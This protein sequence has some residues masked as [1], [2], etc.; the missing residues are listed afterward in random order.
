[1]TDSAT[2]V[3][4]APAAAPETQETPTPVAPELTAHQQ[5]LEMLPE[6]L[7]TDPSF[8]DFKGDNI[9]DV[10][11]K[12]GKS[13]LNTKKLVGADKNALLK[14]PAAEDDKDGWNAVYN[15]LGRPETPEGYGLEDKFKDVPGFSPEAMKE[16]NAV[17]HA[18]GVSAKAL[19]AIASKYFEQN[20]AA[21]TASEEEVAKMQDEYVAA[22]QK[23][24][25]GAYEQNTNKVLMALKQH[26]DPE[27]LELAKQ[28]PHIFDHPAV[29]KTLDKF[30][31][32]S[33]EDAGPTKGSASGDAHMT[34]AEA[35]AAINE[36][37][38][39]AETKKILLSMEDPRRK[40]VLA[41]RAKLFAYAYPSR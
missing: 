3:S 36:M 28:Y 21:V 2:V 11:G 4:D 39:N 32:S 14:I 40:D 31:K 33:S 22:L 27:F 20:G 8:M 29:M 25:G 38:G 17:A 18:N 19:E 15:K 30:I 10:I 37:D 7:R 6:E 1:M 41:R 35:Q 5:F 26:A 23:E 34:P 24:W 13:Y 16:I 9:N 12:L